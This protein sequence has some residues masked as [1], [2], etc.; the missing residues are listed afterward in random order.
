[1]TA[2]G[3]RLSRARWG[4]GQVLVVLLAVA[5]IVAA[6]AVGARQIEMAAPLTNSG[7]PLND[8]EIYTGSILFPSE[9]ETRCHKLRS[10]IERANSKTTEPSIAKRPTTKARPDRR[11]SGPPCGHRSSA[12]ASGTN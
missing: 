4:F 10:T 12:K 6:G 11:C 7:K 8:D 5:A 1:M 2:A 3:Q 9:D